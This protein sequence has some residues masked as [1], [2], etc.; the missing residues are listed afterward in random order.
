VLPAG[1]TLQGK[2]DELFPLFIG[3]GLPVGVSGLVIAALLAAAMSSLSSG[4]SS[5]TSVLA[6]DF[7]PR[8]RP[9]AG[10]LGV[11]GLRLVSA[12]VGAVVVALSVLVGFVEGNLLEL[13]Y[14]LVN[15]F[16]GPLAAIFFLALWVPRATPFGTLAGIAASVTI[17][18]GLAFAQWWQLGFLWLLPLTVIVGL[19]GGMLASLLPIGP[20]AKPLPGGL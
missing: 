11:G 20:A 15:L 2:A 3:H 14:K 1:W 9:D 16:V 8:L 13:C 17:A 18:F 4:V 10:E 12:F 6:R 19:G 7:L 5:V